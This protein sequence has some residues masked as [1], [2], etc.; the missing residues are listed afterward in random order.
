MANTMENMKQTIINSRNI[1]A[2]TFHSAG[3]FII[4]GLQELSSPPVQFRSGA[5][6]NT[7][8]IGWASSGFF[9]GSSAITIRITVVKIIID[10]NDRTT[11]TP[12]RNNNDIINIITS[13]CDKNGLTTDFPNS[14]Y[15]F[16]IKYD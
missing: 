1:A 10:V 12:S 9:L 15:D 8:S 2:N 6:T 11:T 5:L 3:R 4:S 7:V 14:K 13:T 16:I